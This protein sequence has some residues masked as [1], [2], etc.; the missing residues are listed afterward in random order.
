M[1][2]TLL[3]GC[4]K[5]SASSHLSK[6]S[7][8]VSSNHHSSVFS[9]TSPHGL[10]LGISF[11]PWWRLAPPRALRQLSTSLTFCG[12]STDFKTMQERIELPFNSFKWTLKISY[13]I[14]FD[15][16]QRDGMWLMCSL[17]RT[18]ATLLLGHDKCWRNF[19]F[20]KL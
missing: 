12:Q 4:F 2:S 18:N 19:W 5:W 10:H 7:G 3:L 14:Q 17:S 6:R 11:T 8:P 20:P 9:P 13:S 16:C 15:S 1:P